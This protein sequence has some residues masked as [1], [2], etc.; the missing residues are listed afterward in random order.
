MLALSASWIHGLIG[1]SIRASEWNSV[2]IGSG[3]T[4]ADFL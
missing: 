4:Q 1:Q 2:V 3:L